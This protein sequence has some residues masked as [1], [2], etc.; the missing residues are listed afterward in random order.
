[1]TTKIKGYRILNNEELDLIN[2]GKALAEQC[3]DFI[4]KLEGISSNDHNH[5]ALG[6]TNLQQGFMWIIR[7]I[8]QPTT[9]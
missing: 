5:V 9:F 6:K 2:E 8:A 4:A 1:M 7:S 3:G